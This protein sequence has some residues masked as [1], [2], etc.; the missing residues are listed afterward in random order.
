MSYYVVGCQ[1]W[2]WYF[3]FHY[4]PMASDMVDI[5]NIDTRMQRGQPF[6]PFSQLLGCLPPFSSRFLPKAFQPL[7]TSKSSSIIDFYPKDF[8]ID[9]NGSRSSW[10]GVNLLSFV[11][12]GRLSSAVKDLEHLLTPAEVSCA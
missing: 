8:D 7:M 9:M 6:P 1:A 5:A 4:A 2:G 11:D 10:G 3:P 12:A